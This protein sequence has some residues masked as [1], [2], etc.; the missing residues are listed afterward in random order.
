MHAHSRAHLRTHT[1][2]HYT[3]THTHHIQNANTQH[4]NAQ[5]HLPI[6]HNAPRCTPHRYTR[7]TGVD[8]TLRHFGAACSAKRV[9]SGSVSCSELRGR[10]ACMQKN[11]QKNK[12]VCVCVR[13]SRVYVCLRLRARTSLPT[14]A[15]SGM[16]AV[17]VRRE[18]HARML[19][20]VC[21]FAVELCVCLRVYA[22]VS[23]RMC[24]CV[25]TPHQTLRLGSLA[26]PWRVPV[27]ESGFRARV[28]CRSTRT[29]APTPRRH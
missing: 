21:V 29:P 16:A 8:S 24:V 7:T 20:C 14:T 6:P 18:P 12:C 10:H 11:L 19:S 5:R 9:D 23:L 2:M 13:P 3:H 4:N 26:P 22:S 27:R 1:P 15:A 25:C 28:L 17:R